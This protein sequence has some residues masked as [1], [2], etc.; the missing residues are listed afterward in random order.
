MVELTLT[1]SRGS[2]E[3]GWRHG[4]TLGPVTIPWENEMQLGDTPPAYVSTA[5][6][7]PDGAVAEA[8]AECAVL[9]LCATITLPDQDVMRIYNKGAGRCEPFVLHLVRTH[10]DAVLME[11][12]LVTATTQTGPAYEQAN[13]PRPIPSPTATST[14]RHNI[15]HTP[16]CAQFTNTYFTFDGG[17]IRMGVFLA[18]DG[19]LFVKFLPPT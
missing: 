2:L 14:A 16:T 15:L 12:E 9:D 3:L 5:V 7:Y 17:Q 19:A 18:K 10:G 1:P 6:T 13:A 8:R 11:T 4:A